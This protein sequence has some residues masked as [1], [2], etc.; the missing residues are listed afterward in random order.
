ML[1]CFHLLLERHRQTDRR[2]DGR[3]TDIAIS[4]SRVSVVVS[5]YDLCEVVHWLKSKMGEIRHLENRHDY[6]SLLIWLCPIWIKFR[7]LLQNVM[8][9]SVIWLKSKPEVEFQYGGRLGEFNVMPEPP[10]T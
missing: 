1:R 7:R 2:T 9:T 5:I 3:R 6:F 10:T 4:I 8:S